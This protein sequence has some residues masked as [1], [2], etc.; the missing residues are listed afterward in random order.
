MPLTTL[1]TY[2]YLT[3]KS[4]IPYALILLLQ[5]HLVKRF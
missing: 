1:R 5:L 4:G 3:L 2:T